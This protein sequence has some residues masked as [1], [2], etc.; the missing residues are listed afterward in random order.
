MENLKIKAEKRTECGKG[1]S[2]R[3]RRSGFFPGIV[4]GSGEPQKIKI[5]HN[6]ML[7]CLQDPEFYSNILILEIESSEEE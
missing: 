5:N 2:R 7:R 1:P 3:M 6:N 4:Y